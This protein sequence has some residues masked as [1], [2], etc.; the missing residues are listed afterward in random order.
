MSA[1]TLQTRKSGV[2]KGGSGLKAI[3]HK[4]LELIADD[5]G[6]VTMG[7]VD[8]GVFYAR[9]IGVLSV[10]LSER[11]TASLES[12]LDRSNSL[13]YFA[14]ARA[15]CSYDLGA[16]SAFL[17]TVLAHRSQFKSVVLL[18]WAQGI[19]PVTRAFASAL[20][21]PVD[22]LASDVDFEGRLLDVA[23]LARTKLDPNGWLLPPNQ[24]RSPR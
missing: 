24:P 2:F 20:G 21:D 18:T 23:P 9:F 17:R 16:R 22:V 12:A 14:D 19:T 11:H 6:S 3:H 8:V 4:P 13:H 5:E 1:R 10:S 7:W 15:L